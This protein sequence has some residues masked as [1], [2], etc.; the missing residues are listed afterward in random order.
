MYICP[1]TAI[2]RAFQKIQ[3]RIV[4]ELE[5]K[6]SGRPVVF[7]ASATDLAKTQKEPYEP[8]MKQP[9]PQGGEEKA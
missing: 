1:C 8:N 4:R 9:R 7:I 5:K 2:Q 3:V 6:F